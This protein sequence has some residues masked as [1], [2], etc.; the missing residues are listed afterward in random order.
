MAAPAG[1][2]VRCLGFWMCLSRGAIGSKIRVFEGFEK[3]R[4]PVR[5]L[6]RGRCRKGLMDFY[7]S[8]ETPTLHFTVNRTLPRGRSFNGT[9]IY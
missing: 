7:F 1:L 8:A 5:F 4:G 3:K 6:P 2:G 9:Q